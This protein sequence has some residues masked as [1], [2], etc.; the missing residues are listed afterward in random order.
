[1]AGALQ[2]VAADA[3]LIRAQ[4]PQEVDLAERRPVDIGEVQLAVG[5]L[6]GEEAAQAL[7]AARA[8][9]EVRIRQA[10]RV[11]PGRK[12]LARD[13][14]CDLSSRHARLR[15]RAH[16]RLARVD[17]LVPAAVAER[18]RE[19]R[20]RLTGRRLL[21]PANRRRNAIRQLLRAPDH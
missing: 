5:A 13:L 15:K 19:A 11:E 16:E 4:R 20:A 10:R 9:D 12:R 21:D 18:D 1:C 6:P 8:D 14:L 17:E 3:L 2:T 7:L